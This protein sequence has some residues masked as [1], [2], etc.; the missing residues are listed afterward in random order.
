MRYFPLVLVLLI[1]GCDES[2]TAEVLIH[3]HHRA[4]GPTMHLENITT[5]AN[6]TSPE[7]NYTTRTESSLL[8]D[9][10][11]FRQDYDYKPNPFYALI[12]D[13]KT[14]YGLDSL[15]HNQG[16]L[17]EPVIAVIKAHEFHEMLF[18][19]EDRYTDL[20]QIED[21]VFF[22][23]K[24]HQV[25]ASDHLGLPVRLFFHE[26]NDLLIGISQANPYKKGEVIQVHFY[27]WEKKDGIRIFNRVEIKQGKKQEYH[28][29]FQS[30]EWNLTEFQNR[31]VE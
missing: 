6:C 24:V 16:P 31:T 2:N 7:G 28:F 25:K 10:V 5:L 22:E 29:H 9:Y 20:L 30:V 8:D 14:G 23:E 17:S 21:T 19:P 26:K 3:R 27:D 12:L 13:R 15:L 1:W 11:L 4:I 18:Q